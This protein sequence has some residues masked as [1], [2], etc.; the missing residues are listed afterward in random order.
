MSNK[1]AYFLR[2]TEKMIKFY[3]LDLKKK[4]FSL[5][6]MFLLKWNLIFSSLW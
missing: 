6:P 3:F 2:S 1:L 5:F 4:Y